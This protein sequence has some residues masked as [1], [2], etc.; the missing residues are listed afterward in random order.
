MVKKVF[1][2]EHLE[3]E[4]IASEYWE[5]IRDFY[6]IDKF[7]PAIEECV[8]LGDNERKLIIKTGNYVIEKMLKLDDILM[9]M[10]Y[11]IVDTDMP[12]D[13]Y[14]G[15]MSVQEKDNNQLD[16]IWSCDLTPKGITSEELA[17][18]MKGFFNAGLKGM[19]RLISG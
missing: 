1:L 7:H 10:E 12:I 13:T 9:K 15:K 3:T 19:E 18:M 8:N 2:E 16:I 6:S 11:M 4:G 14:N 5:I 17:K